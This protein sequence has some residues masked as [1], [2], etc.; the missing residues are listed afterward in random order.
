MLIV[1]DEEALLD[2]AGTYLEMEGYS[3]AKAQNGKVALNVLQSMTP[4]IIISDIT[5]PEMSGFDLFEKVRAMPALQSTPFI[6]LTGHS[7]PKHVIQGKEL[8]ADD[9]LTKPFDP[10][11]LISTVKGKLKRRQE[12]SNSV[13]QQIEQMKNQLLRL[14]SH[15]MRTPLTSILG[16]TE[17]LA[18]GKESLSQQ[19][20][21][22]FLEMLK[23]GSKRLNNMVEDF[24]LVVKIE[25]GE[26]EREIEGETVPIN[27]QN[28][29]EHIVADCREVF[30]KKRIQCTISVDNRPQML[31]ISAAH[32][33]NVLSRLMDNAC[34]FNHDGGSV[35]IASDIS[36]ERVIITVSDTGTGIPQNK[37]AGLFQKFYQVNRDS[38]EQQGAGLGLYIA[39]RLA[40][41]AHCELTFESQEGKGSTFALAVRKNRS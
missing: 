31:S 34:K 41:F 2:I 20:F 19:D 9:Y 24:L 22:D 36:P 33:Q 35:M 15:E 28:I 30:E 39:R 14:M 6:F 37:Q 16:A 17:V 12:I 32:L 1:D 25:S 40:E 7:D 10:N 26:L 13:S 29:V 38:Q 5:M 23:S 3:V 8:G 21:T 27:L 18:D 4:D 11:I